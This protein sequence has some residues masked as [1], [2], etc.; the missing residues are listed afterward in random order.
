[1]KFA[2]MTMLLAVASFF[3]A[4]S[5]MTDFAVVNETNQPIEVR[6]RVKNVPGGLIDIVGVPALISV[7]S[8]SSKGDTSWQELPSSQY[9]VDASGRYVIVLL[10][11]QSAV[12]IARMHNYGGHDDVYGGE[13]FPIDALKVTG[14]TGSRELNG[15]QARTAFSEESRALYVFVYN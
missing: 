15:Q 1:M 10:P 9:S 13:S 7:S 6:Y 14:A 12:R 4:C 5:Y 8:M 11:P 2:R 3:T